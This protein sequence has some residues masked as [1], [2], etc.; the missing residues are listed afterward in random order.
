MH[1][2]ECD[3]NIFIEKIKQLSNI[4]DRVYLECVSTDKNE[5]TINKILQLE[6]VKISLDYLRDRSDN[7]IAKKRFEVKNKKL[8][9]EY[10]GEKIHHSELSGFVSTGCK[11]KS[12]G[13]YIDVDGSIYRRSCKQ[14]Q[15]IS[16]IKEYDFNIKEDIVDCP[17]SVC[18]FSSNVEVFS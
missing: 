18:N 15:L 2:E 12:N 1:E 10:N 7:V 6:N 16:N 8:D 17:N 5:N 14:K 3:E 11:C 13:L 9:I 4:V